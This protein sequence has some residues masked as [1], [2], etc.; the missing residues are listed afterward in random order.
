MKNVLFIIAIIAAL[1]TFS[2]CVPVQEQTKEERA[3]VRNFIS[4]HDIP[5][6]LNATSIALGEEEI[7]P[8]DLSRAIRFFYAMWIDKYG[9]E[10]EKL[11]TNLNFL[12]V[13]SSDEMMEVSSGAFW[14]DGSPIVEKTRVVGLTWSPTRIWIW[15]DPSHKISDTSLIHEL[16]HVALWSANGTTGD[17]DHEGDKEVYWTDEHTMFIEIANLVLKNNDQ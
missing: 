11:L 13:I 12:T 1:L 7:P 2:C 6:Y 5:S 4:V 17:I 16:I 8:N 3:P 14:V 10:D 15:I 9:D